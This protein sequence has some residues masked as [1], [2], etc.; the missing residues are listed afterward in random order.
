[1]RG[2]PIILRMYRSSV[3]GRWARLCLF[4]ALLQSALPLHA[5]LMAVDA[6]RAQMGVCSAGSDREGLARQAATTE[7]ACAA[8]ATG[9]GAALPGVPATGAGAPVARRLSGSEH[10]CRFT[11]EADCGLPPSTG[12]PAPVRRA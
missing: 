9:T 5:S 11:A 4:V 6:W 10:R 8:C 2:A 1:M 3:L 7:A 12:P